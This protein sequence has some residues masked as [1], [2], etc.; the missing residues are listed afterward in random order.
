MNNGYSY[1]HLLYRKKKWQFVISSDESIDESFF[2]AF[3]VAPFKYI[4]VSSGNYEEVIELDDDVPK[5]Y[6]E[7]ITVLPEVTIS[8]VTRGTV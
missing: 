5:T 3:Y 1:S 4:S 6:D 2:D 7:D 8:L